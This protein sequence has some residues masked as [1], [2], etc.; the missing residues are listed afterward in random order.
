[1]HNLYLLQP[2]K[3]VSCFKWSVSDLL[4]QTSGFDPWV[5]RVTCMTDKVALRGEFY[6]HTSVTLVIESVVK[7][8]LL[9]LST[10]IHKNIQRF[11]HTQLEKR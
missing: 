11:S 1:M 5:F 2:S 10:R 3:A 8:T 4:R 9:Y 6:R 7:R